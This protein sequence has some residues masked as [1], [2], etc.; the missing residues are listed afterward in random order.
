[1]KIIHDLP[2]EVI[3]TIL[4]LGVIV[5][6]PDARY[7]NLPQWFRKDD[8]GLITEVPFKELPDQCKET[9]R[10]YPERV[11]TLDEMKACALAMANWGGGMEGTLTPNE[12]FYQTFGIDISVHQEEY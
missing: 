5:D 4:K 1:M 8:D 11:F 12:Y 2:K 6:E 9:S 10:A 3:E 7:Y